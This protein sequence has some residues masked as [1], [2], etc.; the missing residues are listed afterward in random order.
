MKR[1]SA[2][3]TIYL[4]SPTRTP[5]AAA[6]FGLANASAIALISKG[7]GYICHL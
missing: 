5:L 4:L 2:L 3:I 7:L 1:P 6:I